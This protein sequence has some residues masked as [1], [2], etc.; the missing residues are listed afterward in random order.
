MTNGAARSV[1]NSA[2]GYRIQQDVE[3]GN[4]INP[5]FHTSPP[6]TFGRRTCERQ[7]R[8]AVVAVSRRLESLRDT[9]NSPCHPRLYV[10]KMMHRLLLVALLIVTRLAVRSSAA[11]TELP[12]PNFVFILTDDL[13]WNTLGCMGDKVVQTPNI[14]RLAARGVL[15]RNSFVATSICCVSRASILTGQHERR[16]GI[17]DFRKPLTPAQWAETYPALLRQ[18]GYRTGFIGKFGVGDAP[19][20][21]A[22]AADFDYWRGLPGQA[23]EFFIDPTDPTHTHATAKFGDEALEFLKGCDAKKPFCLSLSFNAP[24]ARDGKPR[25]FQPD[26]RD[27]KLY[28]DATISYPPTANEQFFKLLPDFVQRS[29]GRRRWEHRFATDAMFQRTMR[30]YDRLV[31]GIDREVGRIVDALAARKLADNTLII[32][33][34]DNG[35]FAGDRQLADKWL[36]YEESIRVPLVIFDPRLQPTQRGRTVDA[37]TLNTDFA[38]TLL[39]MAGLPIPPRNCKDAASCR[40]WPARNRLTGGPNSS[41]SITTRRISSRPAKGSAP[42]AGATSTGCRRIPSA[43]SCTTCKPILWNRTISLATKAMQPF[44]PNCAAIGK[45]RSNSSS[46]RFVKRVVAGGTDNCP[47]RAAR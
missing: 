7:T 32:F 5:R 4:R 20:I 40:W 47:C 26:L 14:D 2:T 44:W 22:K 31:T 41:T 39:D 43:K 15:F 12:R 6:C 3:Q 42:S 38:P 18:A 23:G 17:G 24:H 46:D 1:L 27:E 33:T 35:W 28:A 13:R 37:I 11:T 29:E 10:K 19:A 36:M 9:D 34:S 30:D 45:N 8:L 16:H 21:A 25:E